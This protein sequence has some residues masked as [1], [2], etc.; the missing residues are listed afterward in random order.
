MK[1]KGIILKEGH[2]SEAELLV[3]VEI[4]KECSSEEE[5]EEL[6]DEINDK[7]EDAFSGFSEDVYVE[8]VCDNLLQVRCD[9]I[10]FDEAG[11]SLLK[12][13]YDVV[14]CLHIEDAVVL[15]GVHVDGEV[16]FKR[17][18]DSEYNE[19]SVTLEE[20]LENIEY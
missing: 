19:D 18:D 8:A 17:D 10:T 12:D 15:I 2:D 14:S 1:Y 11:V 4:T 6:M 16:W 3:D 13:I 9:A 20:F 5:L 7:L